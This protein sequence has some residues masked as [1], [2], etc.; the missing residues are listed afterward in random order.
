MPQVPERSAM[1]IVIILPPEGRKDIEYFG[2]FPDLFAANG[3][4]ENTGWRFNPELD[5]WENGGRIAVVRPV[6]SAEGLRRCAA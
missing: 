5:L 3:A 2:P 4:L 1:H 6:V